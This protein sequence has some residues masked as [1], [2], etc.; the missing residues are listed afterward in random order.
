MSLAFLE[1]YLPLTRFF[2]SSYEMVFGLLPKLLAI[3]RTVYP[4]D[5]RIEI[6]ARSAAEIFVNFIT[7]QIIQSVLIHLGINPQSLTKLRPITQLELSEV[8][9]ENLEES[10]KSPEVCIENLKKLGLS[11]EEL[12]KLIETIDAVIENRLDSLLLN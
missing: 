2:R 5:R 12:K 9:Q 6:S 4:F 11:E 10:A 7:L 8:P 1:S 3:E